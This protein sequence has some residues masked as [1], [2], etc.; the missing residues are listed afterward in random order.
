MKLRKILA[1]VMAALLLPALC[2][3]ET[4]VTSF[5]PIYL[6]ALNL[7]E[8]IEGL[9]VYNLAPPGTGCLHDYQL[10]TGDLK[11]LSGAQVFLINGGGMESYLAHVEEALPQ[12]PIVDA[13]QG[14]ALLPSASGETPFNAHVWLDAGNACVMVNN[15]AEGLKEAFPQHA[16]ALEANRADY[17]SRLE[18]LDE[19]LRDGLKDVPRRDI[20]TFHEAFPYFAEAYGLRVAAVVALEPDDALSPRQLSDLIDTVTALGNPPLFTEPQYQTMAAEAV[21][22]ATGAK[23]YE[24]DPCVTGPETEIPRDYYEQVMLRNLQVLQNA[25]KE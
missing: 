9:E 3:A 10:T 11:A 22:G 25:L 24:L 21:A 17:I 13:S 15:L 23:I 19:T 14:I 12:L 16:E 8:G 7:T 4:A 2:A 20:V 6:F 18:Q 1:A 5:Y